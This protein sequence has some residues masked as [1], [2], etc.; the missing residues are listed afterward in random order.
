MN[1]LRPLASFPTVVKLFVGLFTTLMLLV[2][3]WAVWIY[4][5]DRG[6]VEP[7]ASVGTLTPGEEIDAIASDSETALAPIWDT[8]HA[9]EPEPLDDPEQLARLRIRQRRGRLVEDEQPRFAGECPGDGGHGLAH[10]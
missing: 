7:H 3:L 6:E 8:N 9:G 10:G 4:T 2:C 1:D 5:V